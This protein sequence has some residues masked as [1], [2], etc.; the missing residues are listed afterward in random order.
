MD[1]ISISKLK[2]Y[3]IIGTNYNERLE[4]Q[5]ILIDIELFGNFKD[6]NSKDS[7]EYTLNY[8]T[9]SNEVLNYVKQSNHYLIETLAEEISNICLKYNLIRKVKVE[10]HKPQALKNALNVSIKIERIKNL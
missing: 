5:E 2:C 6:K 8:S 10:V 7:V 4:K 1:T 3:C 9:L